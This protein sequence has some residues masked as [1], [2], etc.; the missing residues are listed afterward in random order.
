MKIINTI[1]NENCITGMA[2]MP[3]G[4]IKLIITDPPFAINFKAKKANYNRKESL[5]M[6]GY[7]DIPED[8]YR[9]FSLS[10]LSEA[11]RVLHDN[12]SMYIFTGF[13]HLGD[14][15][16]S[17][18]SLDIEVINHIVWQYQFG[19]YTSKKYVTSHYLVLYCAKKGAHRYFNT[20]SRFQS[21]KDIYRDLQDVW[22]IKRPYW[23][24]KIKTPNKLPEEII[25]KILSY[26]SKKNDLV[27]DPFL[28]SGQV[29]VVSKKMKRRY[30]GFEIAKSYYKF[31]LGRLRK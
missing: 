23:T 15:L 26:S 6:E 18:E 9:H 24:G 29:A 17:L 31:A 11:K 12:G 20:K 10:W 7:N 14:I 3:K 1:H 13:N 4:R 22:F 8:E 28:G 2:K 30:C 25:E 19:V 16:I 27:L 21:T 5:V